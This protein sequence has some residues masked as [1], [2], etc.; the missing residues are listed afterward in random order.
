M[1]ESLNIDGN[2][3]GEEFL[4]EEGTRDAS[5]MVA[6]NGR[7][8][9]AYAC[10]FRR[11]RRSALLVESTLSLVPETCRGKRDSCTTYLAT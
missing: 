11:A 3:T 6:R 8:W 5:T 9:C 1:L 2:A 7:R 4:D 10:D